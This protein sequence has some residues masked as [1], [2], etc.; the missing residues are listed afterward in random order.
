M[1]NRGT[2]YLSMGAFGRDSGPAPRA[3]LRLLLPNTSKWKGSLQEVPKIALSQRA[4]VRR[5][6]TKPKERSFTDSSL[7]R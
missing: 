5:C 4:G 1:H 2:E 6:Q 3:I 7:A